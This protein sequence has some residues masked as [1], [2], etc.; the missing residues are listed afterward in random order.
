M[1]VYGRQ[2]R[3][4]LFQALMPVKNMITDMLAV[5]PVLPY[6]YTFEEMTNVATNELRVTALMKNKHCHPFDKYA[7]TCPSAH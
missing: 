2:A 4:L 7:V 6:R 1:Y 3:D 5:L